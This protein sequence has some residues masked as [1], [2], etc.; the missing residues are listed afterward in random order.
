[1]KRTN[2]AP[3]KLLQIEL[4]DEVWRRIKALAA[5]RAVTLKEL[6]PMAVAYYLQKEE[7]R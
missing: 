1:M 3:G 2:G 5:K 6:V 4:P 7:S